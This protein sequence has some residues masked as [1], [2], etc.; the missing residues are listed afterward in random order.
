VNAS[1]NVRFGATCAS[2]PY[3]GFWPKAVEHQRPLTTIPAV[4]AVKNRTFADFT[5]QAIL[6]RLI[7][8]QSLTSSPPSNESPTGPSNAA[9]AIGA[10]ARF[11]AAACHYRMTDGRYNGTAHAVVRQLEAAAKAL[12]DEDTG[13]LLRL[14][15]ARLH[16]LETSEFAAAKMRKLLDEIAVELKGEP[17]PA[18]HQW[19]CAAN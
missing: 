13:A 8:L 6:Q 12:T 10:P 19:P 4:R 2:I 14:A 3:G 15:A 11:C 18:G 16:Q 1:S 9:L 17:P 7:R 5:E